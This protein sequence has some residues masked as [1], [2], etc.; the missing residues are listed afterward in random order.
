MAIGMDGRGFALDN[1]FVERLWRSVQY[2]DVYLKG[3]AR[4]SELL[5]GLTESFAFDNGERPHQALDNRTPDAV[6]R[7][8]EGGGASSVDRFGGPPGRDPAQKTW[9]SAKPLRLKESVQPK[10]EG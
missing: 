2:E 8:G 1:L 3:Y 6:Y 5:L 4:L 9:G 10:S 7:M